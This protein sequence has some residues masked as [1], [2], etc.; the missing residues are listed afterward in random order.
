MS[1]LNPS[2]SE[3]QPCFVVENSQS[4]YRSISLDIGKNSTHGAV[5]RSFAGMSDLCLEESM[6]TYLS[7]KPKSLQLDAT[8]DKEKKSAKELL[9]KFQDYPV[10]PFHGLS[11]SSLDELCGEI[12]NAASGLNI[13]FEF[14]QKQGFYRCELVRETARVSFIIQLSQLKVECQKS[15]NF[16]YV[17]EVRRMSGAVCPMDW[18]EIVR[19]IFVRIE[20]V[21]RCNNT[22]KSICTEKIIVKDSRTFGSKELQDGH[23]LISSFTDLLSTL[24]VCRADNVI[25]MAE[26]IANS[27]Q[28]ERTE[29]LP[30]DAEADSESLI[31]FLGNS[32]KDIARCTCTILKNMAFAGVFK[33]VSESRLDSILRTLL[34]KVN[35]F[36]PED[37]FSL[38]VQR[39]A[40]HAIVA[41][42]QACEPARGTLQLVAATFS[43]CSNSS[44]NR[45]AQYAQQGLDI[46]SR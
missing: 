8:Y 29:F 4:S 10:C 30:R 16:K 23:S 14:D 36:N 45:L 7:G 34:Q 26:V 3:A 28:C 35:S 15:L 9:W 17:V 12:E 46:L 32:N 21:V 41:T 39:E 1:D 19:E 2:V 40:L 6:G 27:T 43:R 18:G 13:D 38:E 33:H 24:P 22:I 42:Y 11:N 20:N 44:D 25:Q 31:A 5:Y 37:T